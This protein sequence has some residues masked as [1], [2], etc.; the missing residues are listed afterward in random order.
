M[1]H[2]QTGT[3]SYF[4]GR[5]A[6]YG[7]HQWN[8]KTYKLG[9]DQMEQLRSYFID[10]ALYLQDDFGIDQNDVYFGGRSG[11]WLVVDAD[12]SQSHIDHITV[13]VNEFKKDPVAFYKSIFE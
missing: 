11:G 8:V 12:L 10:D 7:K 5:F 9:D 4:Q 2:G 3:S 1:I 6:S 13:T